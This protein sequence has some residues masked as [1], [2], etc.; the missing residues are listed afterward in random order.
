MPNWC[1]NTLTVLG[2]CA[3]DVAVFVAAAQPA[4]AAARAAYPP[5]SDIPF[6]QFLIEYRQAQPLL[7]AALVPEPSPQKY[8][9][10]DKATAT[11]CRRCAG[12]GKRPVTDAIT[13]PA[14][15][16]K[17]GSAPEPT[18]PPHPTCESCRGTGRV[19]E[20]GDGARF[21]WRLQNW[22]CKWEP[23][24]TMTHGVLKRDERADL[25][26]SSEA[27]GLT[28]A[29]AAA[30]YRFETPWSPPIPFVAHAA[31]QFPALDFLLT[32]GEPGCDFAGRTRFRG[33]AMIEDETLDVADVLPAEDL[34]F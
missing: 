14:G 33:G 30:V 18:N 32:F 21:R 16:V 10:R 17:P 11:T 28:L 6:D 3:D 8:A 24:F 12:R 22:G 25:A 26:A 20:A 7:F 29:G 9:D 31:A 19:V 5:D 15:K 13:E 2:A 1:H 27:R 23:Q 34:W 4:R